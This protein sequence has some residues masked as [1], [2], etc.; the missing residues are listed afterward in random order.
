VVERHLKDGDIVLFNRQPS[1]HRMSMMGHIVKVLPGRTFRLHL[2]V[3]PPYNADFDGD[4]MNLHVPQ[5]E[6]ARAEA[7]HLLRVQYHILTPRYGG[8]IIGG[9]QDYI[10]GAY[11]LTIKST[12]LTR[13]ELMELLASGGVVKEPPEPAIISPKRLWTGKQVISMF[14]PESFD[15]QGRANISSG[16]LKCE[17]IECFWDSFVVVR[18]GKL[19]LGVF[20]KKIAGAEQQ[21]SLLYWLAKEYGVE[22]VSK[23]MDHV[24]RIF[25][26]IL[27]KKG[28]TLRLDDVAIDE[29]IKANIHGLLNEAFMRV[30]EYVKQYVEGSLEV[31][32]GR[33]LEESLEIRILE[34]LAEARDRAGEEAVS[35]LDPFNHAF[36]MA[37]TGARGNILNLTQMAATL[38][39]MTV[40][41]ERIWRGYMGRALPHFREND[42]G[43]IA[44]GFVVNSFFNGLS[45]TEMFMHA[46]G[47]REG[48]VDTAVRTSQSGYMQR[49]L[50]NALQD[51]YVEY[52][53]T[54]RD[55]TGSIIQF[56]Y[57][58][59][60][61]DPSRTPHTSIVDIDRVM[62]KVMGW[63]R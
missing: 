15:Y 58:E 51:L 44:R 26:K 56:I 30:Q 16:T 12:L 29:K 37:R 19:L 24:F 54:V 35:N 43:P 47:G 63:R 46:A 2:A 41:G 9:I 11:M 5:T 52:D 18:R 1:L 4:E 57:G 8:M 49:R 25:I 10:S 17:D 7:R 32:P 21:E 27:E 33:S 31:V 60:K 61:A 48:L 50:I 53:Y 38:G 55:S 13:E 39:Q 36:I 6:E 45:V 22:F 20:D 42:L 28:F 40:R 14:L 23:F 34:V 59:D 62:N 3:C